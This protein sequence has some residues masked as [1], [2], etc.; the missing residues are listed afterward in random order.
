M[1]R[2]VLTR[3]LA[4]TDFSDTSTIAL[5]YAVTLAEAF[6]AQLHLLH[7]VERSIEQQ[8]AGELAAVA[9]LDV[10]SEARAKSDAEL[11]TLLTRDERARLEARL[12]SR[13]GTPFVEIVRYAQHEEIDLI[14]MGTHG[15]GAIAHLLIGS[16][17]ENVVRKARCPVLTVPR[18]GHDFIKP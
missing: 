16:V 7:V 13:T 18:A 11:A 17:A 12:V 3:I 6:H 1:S 8:W 4:P 5:R 9:A 14:V 15:R 10:E 2:I